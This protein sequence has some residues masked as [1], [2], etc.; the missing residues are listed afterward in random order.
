MKETE[1]FIINF[2]S[3]TTD[4]FNINISINEIKHYK[5]LKMFVKDFVVI[6]DNAAIDDI[7]PNIYTLNS[8]TLLY[9]NNY[10]NHNESA[11]GILTQ[12]KLMS[13]STVLSS[14][15]VKHP[16][17]SNNNESYFEIPSINGIHRFWIEDY[18]AGARVATFFY[19]SLVVV[20][21]N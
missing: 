9:K 2:R 3:T 8:D 12:S 10:D 20:A 15:T 17:T 5:K 21:Y 1:T 19:V 18:F 14:I 4:V 7:S 16:Y 11:V 13:G 6:N